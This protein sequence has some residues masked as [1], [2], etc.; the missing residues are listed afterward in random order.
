MDILT[1]C[2]DTQ[3]LI[4]E[5]ET[6]Y[7]DYVNEGK[8][9]IDKIPIKRNGDE[10]LTLIKVDQEQFEA[11]KKLDSIAILGTY[12][13]VFN[14]TDKKAIYDRVYVR[15]YKYIDDDG[16]EQTGMKPERLGEFAN[17]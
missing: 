12:D 15:E 6:K 5:L 17:E 8:F 13:E 2:T 7:P 11:I 4:K 14:D 1:H 9:L 3:A 16:K 10:T